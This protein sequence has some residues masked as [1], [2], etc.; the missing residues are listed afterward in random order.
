MDEREASVHGADPRATRRDRRSCAGR[1]ARAPAA[2]HGS[3]R[4]RLPR[5]RSR[6]AA[7][8]PHPGPCAFSSHLWPC[9]PFPRLRTRRAAARRRRAG[10]PL[11]RRRRSWFRRPRASRSST[12]AS[13]T[14]GC[15]AAPGTSAR[16]TRFVGDAQRWFAQDD[17]TG[18]TAIRV[19]HNWNATD[20]TLDKASVGWYRKEF[21]LPAVPKDEAKRTF[22]KIRFEGANYR[23]K[24]WL[25]GKTI[26]G[27]GGYFPFEARPDRAAPGPQHARGQ[28]LLAAQQPRPH[29]LAPGGLQRLRHGRLVELRRAAARGLRAPHRHGR[30]PRSPGAAAP[31]QAAAGPPR[32]RCAPTCAT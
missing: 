1:P 8:R 11:R 6:Y 32:S 31:A 22:W 25:N 14:A 15:S 7:A 16:T 21:K 9:W 13:P 2:V 3:S 4:I 17:L 26:G 23:T 12:R 29:P 19:P 28:G 10:S 18:W 5:V 20:T 27:Y 30:H 24:V